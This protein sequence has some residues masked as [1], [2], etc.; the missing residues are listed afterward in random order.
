MFPV[1]LTDGFLATND[2]QLHY[3]HWVPST[4]K[5]NAHPIL[6]LHGLAS[7]SY[8]WNLV[9]PRLA[10]QGHEVVALDQRGHGESSK[11]QQGYDFASI[12]ADDRALIQ[13]LDLR[14]PVLVGH[15]WGAM[16]A[17]EYAA[18]SDADVSAVVLVDGALQ[19][20]SRRPGW[21]LEQAL[22]DLAPPRYAGI[23]RETFLSFFEKSPLARQWTPEL[24]ASALHIVEQ[25][26]DGTVSP[27]LAFENHLQIIEAMWHQSTLELYKNVRCPIKLVIAEREPTDEATRLRAEQREIGLEEIRAIQ[28]QISIVHMPDTIHDVP[29]QRPAELAHEILALASEV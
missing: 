7:S 23:S 4:T 8:I 18:A 14:H 3:R 22:L 29:L 1:S 24:E 26:P 21:S 27:R 17:L 20:F 12:V 25:H 11:P 2:L 13:E 16:V 19:Q 9:A 6:L 5:S 28:P 15:S 10:E